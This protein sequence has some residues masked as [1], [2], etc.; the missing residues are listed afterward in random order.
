[1]F[2]KLPDRM[3]SPGGGAAARVNLAPRSWPPPPPVF[4]HGPP[5]P[6][7]AQRESHR[8]KDSEARPLPLTLYRPGPLSHS[9][10][11]IATTGD[12]PSTDIDIRVHDGHHDS[13]RRLVLAIGTS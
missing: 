7:L 10:R 11:G 2:P 6:L 3:G 12:E 4:L 8:P 13:A 5:S 1:M 9:L